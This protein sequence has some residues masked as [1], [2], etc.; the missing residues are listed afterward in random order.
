[1]GRATANVKLIDGDHAELILESVREDSVDRQSVALRREANRWKITSVSSTARTIPKI[2]YGT[3][4]DAQ[5]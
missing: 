2:P 1:M 5:Q 4:V 3:P